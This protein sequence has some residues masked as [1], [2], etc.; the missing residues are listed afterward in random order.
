LRCF[1]SERY[2]VDLPPGHVFPM[3]KFR[4]AAAELRADGTATEV[5]DAGLIPREDL[6]RVHTAEYVRSIE[7]ADLPPAAAKKLGLPPSAALARRSY[8]AVAGTLAAA[9]AALAD[10]LACNLAGGTHHSFADRGEGFCV[11]NDVAV[12]IRV[13]RSE[14]PFLQSMVIDLDAHQGNGTH[15]I[16][17]SDPNT[18]TYSVHVGRNY[19]SAKQPGDLDVPLP[20]WVGGDEYLSAVD[21]T[22]PAAAERF[23][24][25]LAFYIAGVDVHEADRFGQMKLTKPE[26]RQRDERVLNL[27]RDWGVPTVI[28]YGGGYQPTTER[29]ATLHAEGVRAARRRWDFERR[30]YRT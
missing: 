6:L 20:R 27:L 1:Y 30:T 8:A 12:A 3:G 9:R 10:G 4:L 2:H 13:L 25:D 15:D 26:M 11:F 18:F 14:E 24:P 17:N 23:E 5:V 16:F 21:A 22:L 7:E 19:P 28:L 29:T